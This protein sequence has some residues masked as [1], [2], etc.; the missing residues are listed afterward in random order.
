M[1]VVHVN[2]SSSDGLPKTGRRQVCVGNTALSSF[3]MSAIFKPSATFQV[4]TDLLE[5]CH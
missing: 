1:A 3:D 4:P 5:G 2:R